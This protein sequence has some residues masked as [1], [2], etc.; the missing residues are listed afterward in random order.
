MKKQ[1]NEELSRINGMMKMISEEIFEDTM[2]PPHNVVNDAKTVLKHFLN[3]E[4]PQADETDVDSDGGWFA[5]DGGN[6]KYIKYYFDVN[7]RSHGHTRSGYEYMDNGDPGYPDEHEPMDFDIVVTQIELGKTEHK[8]D[9]WVDNVEYKGPDF[10]NFS[11]LSFKDGRSGEEWLSNTFDDRIL[12]TDIEEEPTETINNNLNE[13]KKMSKK[14]TISESQLQRL[15]ERKH[16]YA[17]NSPESAIINTE[18]GDMSHNEGEME[19]DHEESSELFD[20][21]KK[22]FEVLDKE[23]L[24]KIKS[25]FKS[26][27]EENDFTLELINVINELLEGEESDDEEESDGDM[28]GFEGTSDDLNDISLSEEDHEINESI[29]GIKANFKRFL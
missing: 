4:N 1:L 2:K 24:L 17:D 22:S 16:S 15:M 6:N 26:Q 5:I 9:Q 23:T 7:V 10:T 3:Q 29:E 12:E 14:I 13:N 25:G 21:L 18:E 19:E 27:D 8:D 11:S 28:P 20:S